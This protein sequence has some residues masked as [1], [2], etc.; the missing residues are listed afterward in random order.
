MDQEILDLINRRENQILLH[1]CIYYKFNDNLI[2]DWQ[3]DSIGKDLLEL[4][5]DYPDEFEAS[6]HYEE[7]IDYVNSETPSG[8][9]LRY[10]SYSFCDL[11]SNSDFATTRLY[12]KYELSKLRYV[13]DC[14]F[15][16]S[17]SLT[18]FRKLICVILGI[19]PLTCEIMFNPSL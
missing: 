12:S 16:K 18:N 15:S 9:N 17:C 11:N 5:K 1:S 2:E 6:Y 7:F 10:S 3:Y 4:A 13:S 19:T 8:F 14:I